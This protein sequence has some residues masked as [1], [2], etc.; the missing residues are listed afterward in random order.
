MADTSVVGGPLAL[1][2]HEVERIRA[3]ERHVRR[4]RTPGLLVHENVMLI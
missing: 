4:A 1:E 3:P 2:V